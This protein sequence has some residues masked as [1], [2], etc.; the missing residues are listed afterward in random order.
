MLKLR[1]VRKT[2]GV[3]TKCL[4]VFLFSIYLSHVL[5]AQLI[6]KNTIYFEL[7]GAAGVYSINYDRLLLDDFDNNISLRIGFSYLNLFDDNQHIIKGIPVGISYLTAFE[8]LYTELGVSFSVLSESYQTMNGRS[9]V[10]TENIML[11]PS[12]RMGIR[13]QQTDK[14]LF[15]NAL[16]QLSGL[17]NGKDKNFE[18]PLDASLVAYLSLGLGYSI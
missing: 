16:F 2:T 17:I 6:R 1:S 12:I 7:A 4:N 18:R 10:Q 8:N 15:W 3:N 11:I 14:R 5:P 13:R 9:E